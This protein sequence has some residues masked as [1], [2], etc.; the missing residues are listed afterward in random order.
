MKSRISGL[1]RNFQ[2]GQY[3]WALSQGLSA[4]GDVDAAPNESEAEEDLTQRLLSTSG[5]VSH[6]RRPEHEQT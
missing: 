2:H 6:R 5:A 1:R 4:H 3:P